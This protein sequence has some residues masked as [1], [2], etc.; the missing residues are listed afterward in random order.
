MYY[1][2]VYVTPLELPQLPSLS[3]SLILYSLFTPND[4]LKTSPHAYLLVLAF[5]VEDVQIK[6]Y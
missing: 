5:V 1:G 3:S 4:T 2:L 6:M